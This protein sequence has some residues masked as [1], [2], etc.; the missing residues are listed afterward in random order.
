MGNTEQLHEKGPPYC[1]TTV[2]LVSLC[3]IDSTKS[4]ENDAAVNNTVPGLIYPTQLMYAYAKYHALV[5]Q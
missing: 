5:L 2:C 3:T 1:C 4:G